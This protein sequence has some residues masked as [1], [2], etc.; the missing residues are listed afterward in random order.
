MSGYEDKVNEIITGYRQ[1]HRS[2]LIP[3]LQDIQNELGYISEMAIKKVGDHLKIPT[4]K[5][6]GLATFYNQFRLDKKGMYHIQVCNG[7]SCH[8]DN[9]AIILKEIEK[10][11][12][13]KNGEVTRDGWFSL[14]ILPCI[15]ACAQSPV[16]AVNGKYHVKMDQFKTRDLIQKLLEEKERSND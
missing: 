12:K 10:L 2:T 13:I 8:L 16:L 4:S 15:G 11:L 5:I 7:S 3:I 1:T 14:E 6:Y 9:N